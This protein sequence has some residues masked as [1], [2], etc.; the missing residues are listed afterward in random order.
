MKVYILFRGVSGPHWKKK[1]CLGPHIKYTVTHNTKNLITFYGSLEFCVGP[2][3]QQSW[4][5]MWPTGRRLDTPA[6]LRHVIFLIYLT[7]EIEIAHYL[8]QY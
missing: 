2:H 5:K 1:S 4:A 7:K 6:G 8:P 3:S